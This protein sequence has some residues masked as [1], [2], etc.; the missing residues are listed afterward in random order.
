MST[1][2]GDIAADLG[3]DPSTLTTSVDPD[4]IGLTVTPLPDDNKP[5]D[6]SFPAGAIAGIVVGVVVVGLILGGFAYSKGACKHKK[7]AAPETTA[8]ASSAVVQE[9]DAP[10][11]SGNSSKTIA[12]S[13]PAGTIV[14]TQAQV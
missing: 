8:T 4:A 10:A 13:A 11:P 3:I 1:T 2:L 6:S 14:V 7:P 9:W 5:S 12:V